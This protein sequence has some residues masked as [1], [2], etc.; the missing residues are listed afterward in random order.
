MKFYL[1]GKNGEIIRGQGFIS[2]Q[3]YNNLDEKEAKFIA[4][5]RQQTKLHPH[6][7]LIEH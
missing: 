2:Q 7:D 5:R 6:Y 1:E 3:N 4:W